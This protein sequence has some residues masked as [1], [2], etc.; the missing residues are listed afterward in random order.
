MK[1]ANGVAGY[2][3]SN[4]YEPK[5]AA[6]KQAHK[7]LPH[8]VWRSK[9]SASHKRGLLISKRT[10]DHWSVS[11]PAL[12]Y[13][14][15][16]EADGHIDKG[17]LVMEDNFGNVVCFHTISQV[18]EAIKGCKP[19]MSSNPDWGDYFFLDQELNVIGA[20]QFDVG[21]NL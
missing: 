16:Q 3:T 5:S 11:Q 10:R 4:E 9:P 21:A 15:K 12:E 20:G 13:I 2:L 8:Q 6:F 18:L 7:L 17:Y 19:N 1:M 14:Q